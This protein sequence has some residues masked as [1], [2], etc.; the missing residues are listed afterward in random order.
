MSYSLNYFKAVGY[1]TDYMA[2]EY[3]IGVDKGENLDT[4]SL[5]LHRDHIG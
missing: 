2:G 5:G 3:K 1:I 4:R